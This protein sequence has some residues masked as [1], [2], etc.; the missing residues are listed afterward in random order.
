MATHFLIE[1]QLSLTQAI[2]IYQSFN[3]TKNTLTLSF[4]IHFNTFLKYSLSKPNQQI[5]LD[6]LITIF[7][8]FF[9]NNYNNTL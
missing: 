4:L 2:A 9:K 6:E 7:N 8:I 3:N 1:K 5:H